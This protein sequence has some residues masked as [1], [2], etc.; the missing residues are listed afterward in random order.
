MLRLALLLVL[1]ASGSVMAQDRF[2]LPLPTDAFPN[3]VAVGVGGAPDYL[4]SDEY[5]VGLAPAVGLELGPT[6]FRMLGNWA[7]LDLL[8]KPN[9]SI[10]PAAV[11]RFG[12]FDVDDAVVSRLPGI[13]N[14]VNLGINFGYEY[15]DPDDPFKRIAFGIDILHDVGGVYDGFV[16]NGFARGIYPLPWRGGALVTVL[17]TTYGGDAYGDT[18]FSVSSADAAASGLPQYAAGAGFRDARLGLGLFQSLS[19][20]WHV[21]AG[22]VY[23]RLV[24][25]AADSPIVADRGSPNQFIFGVGVAYTWGGL[26]K[27]LDI[28]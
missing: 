3:F 2:A 22:V 5:L 6:R 21:G 8:G 11:Y 25:D 4:G 1:F 24:G 15:V 10:G 18:Y 20:N 9:F 23:S 16:V 13:D 26:L 14:T 17:G 28:D 12:R 19:L 7:M 27:G